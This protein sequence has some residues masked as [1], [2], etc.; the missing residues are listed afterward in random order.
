MNGD[1]LLIVVLVWFEQVWV[2]LGCVLPDFGDAFSASDFHV[3]KSRGA[4][5]R[6]AA[7]VSGWEEGGFLSGEPFRILLEW[8]R[9][10]LRLG[11]RPSAPDLIYRLPPLPPSSNRKSIW[12]ASK[13]RC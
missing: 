3:Q 13:I 12:E 5:Q 8:D 11:F 10:S 2:T 1:I 6:S 9:M 7:D 4:L